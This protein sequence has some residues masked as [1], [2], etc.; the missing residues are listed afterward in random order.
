MS[1]AGSPSDSLS[2]SQLPASAW[3]GVAAY[4]PRT[5]ERHKLLRSSVS[6]LSEYESAIPSDFPYE[7]TVMP[8]TGLLRISAKACALKYAYQTSPFG[9]GANDQQPFDSSPSRVVISRHRSFSSFT[10][11]PP[12]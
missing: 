9:S 2:C 4:T 10:T 7:R 3:A 6:K 11:A 12:L 1:S 8:P 5:P